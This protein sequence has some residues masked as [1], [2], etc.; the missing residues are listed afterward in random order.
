MSTKAATPQL[1][2]PFKLVARVSSTIASTVNGAIDGTL[3]VLGKSA[4]AFL[5]K[6]GCGRLKFAQK[7]F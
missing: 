3:S 4:N 7:V 6:Y 2:P 1:R 5:S